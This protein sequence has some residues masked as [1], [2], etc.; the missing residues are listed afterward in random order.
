MKHDVAA[1]TAEL[2]QARS[3]TRVVCNAHGYGSENAAFDPA[4]VVEIG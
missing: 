1:G 2:A 4:L 3:A